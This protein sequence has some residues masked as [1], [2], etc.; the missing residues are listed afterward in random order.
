MPNALGLFDMH[1]NANEW[2]QDKYFSSYGAGDDRESLER[3]RTSF[4][5]VLRGGSFNCQALNL[6][7]ADRSSELPAVGTDDEGFR[8]ARTIVLGSE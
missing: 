3:I 1:G 8:I 5:R 6:R 2:C 4:S 7:C